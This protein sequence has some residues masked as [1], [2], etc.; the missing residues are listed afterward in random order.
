MSHQHRF[1]SVYAVAWIPYLAANVTVFLLQERQQHFGSAL[2]SALL[3]VVPAAL[4]GV[5]VVWGTR[6]VPL[7]ARPSFFVLHVAA[8]V[9]YSILW[10]VMLMAGL[11]VRNGILRGEWTLV[12]FGGVALY[13][14]LL[15]GGLLY[16][17]VAGVT[18]A[19]RTVSE[20][21]R[22]ED[23]AA[24]A[25]LRLVQAEAL[26]T[27]A[28]LLALRA[29]LNP[30]FL[31][32][33][34][35][36]VSALVRQDTA[37]AERAL[38]RFAHMLRYVLN[39]QADGVDDIPLEAEWRFTRD[40][41]ALEELRLGPRLRVDADVDPE[42]LDTLIPAFTLQPLVENALK[43]AIAPF[44]QGGTVRV[45]L[46]FSGDDLC[47]VVSDDGPG[48]DP[49]ALGGGPG[50]GLRVVRQR[51]D[52]RYGGRA[53]MEVDSAPGRGFRVMVRIPAGMAPAPVPPL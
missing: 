13:W 16:P 14:Q 38:E 46:H 37:A 10:F 35:H 2:L 28:E 23:R 25:E 47:L 53:L 17:V 44:T 48:A 49:V 51:L 43:H 11:T 9:G 21:R 41:L 1:W 40:Y 19:V 6:K 34:L 24:R 3:N 7:R 18:Y 32:N 4:L 39:A 42:T 20:L 15:Q 33:T 22:Q 50:V 26:R 52:V 29:R 8:A 45:G 31:F 30:H 5:I 12:A 27:A 36:S